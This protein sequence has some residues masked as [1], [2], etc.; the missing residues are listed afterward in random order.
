M[1][2]FDVM[3]ALMFFAF[4]MT[5]TPGPNN[6]LLLASG[7]AFGVRR[8]GWH[9]AGIL[10]GVLLQIAV[11]GAGLGMLFAR[12]PRAQT[13]LMIAGSLYMLWLARR[14]W[15]ASSL[16]GGNA[17]RP[18]RF[19][20]AALFQFLNPKTWLMATTVVAVFVPPGDHYAQRVAVA[21]MLFNLVALPCIA[22][23]AVSGEALGRWIHDPVALQR[24][25]RLMAVLT[26]ATVIMFWV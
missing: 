23:W 26:M 18:I 12:E 19:H 25:N 14:L 16:Q 1:L 10:A 6:V 9:M 4:V 15:L 24:I 11:V 17:A 7:L 8:T 2:T 13:A 22:L 20:E 3:L 21:G 5:I